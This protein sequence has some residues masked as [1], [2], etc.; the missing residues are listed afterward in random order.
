MARAARSCRCTPPSWSSDGMPGP[1]PLVSVVVLTGDDER[2]LHAALESLTTQDYPAIEVVIAE[3]S[4]D[5]TGAVVRGFAE[6]SRTR[7][8]FSRLVVIESD[9]SGGPEAVNRAVSESRG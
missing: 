7:A 1:S 6:D 9:G 2:H 5:R 3:G 8:R 4:R